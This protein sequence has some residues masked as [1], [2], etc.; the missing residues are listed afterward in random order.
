MRLMRFHVFF[1]GPICISYGDIA[2]MRRYFRASSVIYMYRNH[3]MSTC[4]DFSLGLYGAGILSRR[5]MNRG[6]R[7]FCNDK[8]GCFT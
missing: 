5:P 1:S 4:S 6:G 7:Y 8:F 2:K 3:E